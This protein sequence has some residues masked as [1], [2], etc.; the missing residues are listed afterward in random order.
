MRN[1][2]FPHLT[3]FWW[4][5]QLIYCKFRLKFQYI[6]ILIV[7]WVLNSKNL[8]FWEF[9]F[10]F[11]ILVFCI[12]FFSDKRSECLF[13]ITW[14]RDWK[15]YRSIP[16]HCTAYGDPRAVLCA[17]QSHV[18][19][20]IAECLISFLTT[21]FWMC[22]ITKLCFLYFQCISCLLQFNILPDLTSF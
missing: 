20:L 14:W 16:S 3:F 10:C 12:S 1:D 11:S 17:F 8:P 6:Q 22:F 21:F 9:K 18:V 13:L 19:T 7:F 2:E 4:W 15:T 5:W